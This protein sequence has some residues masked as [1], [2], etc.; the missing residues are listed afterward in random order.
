MAT[1]AARIFIPMEE[2]IDKSKELERLNKDKQKCEADIKFLSGKLNNPKFVDKAPQAVVDAERAK[3]EK[4]NP[5]FGKNQ[6]KYCRA[7]LIQTR[8]T[9]RPISL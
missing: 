2:L 3:L 1:D 6:R 7:W 5:A 8:I 9:C 4:S